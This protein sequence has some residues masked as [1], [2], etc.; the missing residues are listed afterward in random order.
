MTLFIRKP[1]VNI[2]FVIPP[3]SPPDTA[4]SRPVPGRDPGPDRARPD[5]GRPDRAGTGAGTG[6]RAGPGPGPDRSRA[7]AG[8][9]PDR[10]GAGP[11]PDRGQGR[12]V[13][14]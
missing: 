2:N 8:P 10:A 13:G 3:L 6:A 11:E 7:G 14:Q 12:A 4:G 5:R 1:N 9:G